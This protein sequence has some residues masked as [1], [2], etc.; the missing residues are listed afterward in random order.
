MMKILHRAYCI[1][2]VE[3]IRMC[4]FDQLIALQTEKD[5]QDVAAHDEQ[6]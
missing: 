1:V 6:R 3:V 2:N 5:E 4:M